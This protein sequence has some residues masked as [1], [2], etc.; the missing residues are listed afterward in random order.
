MEPRVALYT[1]TRNI[2]DAMWASCKSMIG[3]GLCDEVVLFIEDDEFPYD[4]D[5]LPITVKNVSGQKY[6]RKDGPNMTS[7]FTYMAMMRATLALEFPYLSKIL[8]LD[9]DTF[10]MNDCRGIW[11]LP[12]EHDGG[13]YFSAAYEPERCRP[14]KDS[15]KYCN[16]GVCLYNLDILRST[17]KAVEVI[18]ILNR[19]RFTWLEQDVFS[20]LCQGRI[21][22][23]PPE[24]NHCPP[25]VKAKNERDVLIRHFAGKKMF[26]EKPLAQQW[27]KTSPED[28]MRMRE[29][30]L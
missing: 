9:C 5:I 15:L 3:V 6:F 24:C 19:R 7:G 18:E 29:E 21:L 10:A 30:R 20:F 8:A 13:Y 27:L 2:Y 11:D 23:M 22:E 12:V 26:M 4:T 25:F 28:V 1:G 17:G 16:I 14:G